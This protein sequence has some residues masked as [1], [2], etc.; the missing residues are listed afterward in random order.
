MID[1]I[2]KYKIKLKFF[3]VYTH[4]NYEFLTINLDLCFRIKKYN[5][6]PN[7]SRITTKGSMN[8]ESK[9]KKN[10]Y[11]MFIIHSIYK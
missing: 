5:D 6:A 8:N 3:K 1:V 7:V 9:N 11:T 4:N 2:Y 10:G